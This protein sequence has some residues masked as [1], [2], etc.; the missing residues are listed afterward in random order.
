MN[1]GIYTI[2]E[3]ENYGNR[4]QNYALQKV[5]E[6]KG[7]NVKTL[8][9][10]HYKN[11][12]RFKLKNSIKNITGI[13]KN[14]Y[15]ERCEK[16]NRFNRKYIKFEREKI[17]KSMRFK[18]V[19][20]YDCFVAGSD[21]IWNPNFEI[22]TPASF[23]KFAQNK[24]KISV[25]ASFGVSEIEND[26]IKKIYKEY[27]DDFSAI[28]VRE[29]SGAKIVKELIGKDASVLIDPTLML[30][31]EEWN[32]IAKKP[33][34]IPNG[35]YL[36]CYF[37]GEY[38]KNMVDKIHKY[39]K[40]QKWKVVFLEDV[41]SKSGISSDEEFCMDP[42]EFVW[43]L[44][45]SEK[46]IT[47]SFHAAVFSIIYEKKIITIPRKTEAGDMSTRMTNLSKEFNIKN[48]IT[49]DYNFDH[50]AEMNFEQINRIIKLKQK[51]FNEY[52]EKNLV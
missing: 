5:L 10:K 45:N 9:D 48:L 51:E 15:I 39:A 27:L 26:D 41:W 42:S 30:S 25:A 14:R 3:G 35:K 7:H 40:E 1:I 4:L 17:N 37:L 8:L 21:Q 34:K 52:L 43:L 12:W 20:K 29:E 24:K 6:K 13:K 19:Y 49:Y 32:M 50:T 46:V 2:T 31:K 47:D 36:F 44:K 28:S 23:L 18:R 33:R 38:E 22:T 11:D 16:F